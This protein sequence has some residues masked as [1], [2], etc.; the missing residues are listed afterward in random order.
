VGDTYYEKGEYEK[1]AQ[2]YGAT[3]NL[4]KGRQQTSKKLFEVDYI[5]K[6]TLI[7]VRYLCVKI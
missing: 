7:K 5:N 4:L 2:F 3:I 6:D 1:A